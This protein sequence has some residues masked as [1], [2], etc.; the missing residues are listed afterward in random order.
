MYIPSYPPLDDRGLR[1]WTHNELSEI[2]RSMQTDS[3]ILRIGDETTAITTGLAKFT[4]RMPYRFALQEVRVCMTTAPT[5]QAAIFDVNACGNSVFSTRV[6][7]DATE[8][9]STTAATTAVLSNNTLGDDELITVDFDQVGSGTAGA[10]VKV[11]LIG[12]QA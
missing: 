12:R 2:A 5:G 10:G 3:I 7:V 6:Q 11:T 9:T 4:Y 1:D 8:T